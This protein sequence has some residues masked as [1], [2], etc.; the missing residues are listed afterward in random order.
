MTTISPELKQAIDDAHGAPVRILD[1]ATK[2]E[3]V[4][5]RADVYDRIKDTSYDDGE[6]SPREAYPLVDRVMAEDD[7]GDPTLDSYQT[8]RRDA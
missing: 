3:Y 8:Y 5:V 2:T 6:F 4:V 1:Q 7:A